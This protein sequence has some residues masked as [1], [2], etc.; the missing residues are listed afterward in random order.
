MDVQTEI[1]IGAEFLAVKN[2]LHVLPHDRQ[3]CEFIVEFLKDLPGVESCGICLRG[4]PEPIGKVDT[5]S[6][7]Q[8]LIS[9]DTPH[10][11]CMLGE[12]FLFARYPMKT[13]IR[14]YGYFLV[15]FA[16]S[17]SFESLNSMIANLANLAALTLENR[18]QK[19]RLEI[20]QEL[21]SALAE[22]Q[23]IF[24]A[25]TNL[26]TTFTRLLERLLQL[27]GSRYGFIGEIVPGTGDEKTFKPFAILRLGEDGVI[28]KPSPGG[29]LPDSILLTQNKLIDF[30]NETRKPFI[31]NQMP[32][33]WQE[34][35]HSITPDAPP[36]RTCM[37]LPLESGSGGMGA[38]LIANRDGGYETEL[39]N[40]L[41]PL[42]ES[43]AGILDAWRTEEER[44]IAVQELKESHAKL[45]RLV[46]EKTSDLT[47]SNRELKE[48][49]ARRMGNERK[50]RTLLENLPE[51][52][53]YK[54]TNSIY[55][56]CNRNY[57]ED[58]GIQ[59]EDILLKTD[60]DFF[61]KELADKYRVDDARVMQSGEVKVFEEKYICDGKERLVQ[62]VK[63]P[64]K[65]EQGRA[66]GV[67][68]I[69]RDIT[70]QK[71]AEEE[72][73]KLT[74]A[75]EQSPVSVVITDKE[76]NI[77]YVNPCFTQITGYTE[78][79]ARGQNPRIL[80]S[81]EQGEEFYRDLWQTITSGQVWRGELH[82]KKK[83]GELYWESAVISPVRDERGNITHFI[84][85]KENITQRKA[86]EEKLK[87]AQ[88]Q[89]IE[90][91]KFSAIGQLAAGVSHEVLN[92]LNIISLHVQM[93]MKKHQD[94]EELIRPFEKMSNEIKRIEKIL[95][96]LL[97]FSRKTEISSES[98][99]LED[100]LNDVISLL[101]KEFELSNI[102]VLSQF[103]PNL[104]KVIVEKDQM[105]Q[106]FLNLINNARHA[107]KEG[108]ML[109]I[110]LQPVEI[111]KIPFIKMQFKDTGT[112]IT[113]EHLSRIF[114]PFF[115]TK[116]EGEG[117]G[118]GLPICLGII[119]KHGGTI[120]I[121]SPPGKG[122][123]VSVFLPLNKEQ[124]E[125]AVLPEIGRS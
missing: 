33:E 13:S 69:F 49:I 119:E 4:E 3:F 63:A 71:L 39:M 44:K 34:S 20:N 56:F 21:L 61:P 94:N 78:E 53:F 75:V 117:T 15:N 79:E 72:I 41:T 123:T 115:T 70:E 1:R 80:K 2:M 46:T 113:K 73:R 89:L 114:E 91:E 50:I 65:D 27:T 67:L 48:E 18:S 103:A 122:T 43:C 108:G 118:M 59:P 85:V 112:G 87:F 25:S 100:V 54:D 12:G 42:V 45:E 107:M 37:A 26:G 109:A 76:G 93:L 55:V 68:G 106:V 30:L 10:F 98:V 32:T 92:P 125:E 8:C 11:K 101:G 88:K 83:S 23:G 124:G 96:A 97:T 74:R 51:K 58:L 22:I 52:I 90:T 16:E 77:E 19:K 64:F 66:I 104:P 120:D 81:G 14:T 62:T 111:K 36:I 82:N 121:E 47:R 28:Q 86:S 57:A 99:S 102:R 17:E 40:F 38:A 6:C 35:F 29:P 95:R 9:R 84:G 105:R 7:G 24:I 60:Y 110:S 31:Q 116:P 5:S